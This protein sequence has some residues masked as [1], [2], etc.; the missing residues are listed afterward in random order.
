MYV[1]IDKVRQRRAVTKTD[2]VALIKNEISRADFGP[3]HVKVR[4]KI[5]GK[6]GHFTFDYGFQNGEIRDLMHSVSFACKADTAYR[7]AKALAVS[8]E[9]VATA[10]D[11]LECVAVMRPP[12][13]DR[14]RREFYVPAKGHLED[15][16]CLVVDER[17]IRQSLLQI[18]KKTES[19]I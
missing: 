17:G 5:N 18:R 11:G 6:I 14:D 3:E 13:S 1:G 9:D 7:D 2:L 16:K 4:P 8:F 12:E 10:N 19:A 15:K